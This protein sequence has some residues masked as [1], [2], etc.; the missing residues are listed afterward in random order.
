MNVRNARPEDLP[1]ILR[2]IEELGETDS[3]GPAATVEHARS[4]LEH[5]ALLILVAEEGGA[6]IGFLSATVRPNLYHGA[7]AGHVD[8]LVVERSI[9]AR[10]VGTALLQEFLERM[11]ARGAAE[12]SIG[13]LP[14]NEGAARLYRR[15][16]FTEEVRLLEQHFST[17][18]PP[19]KPKD[20]R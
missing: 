12:V 13:V 16:G 5:P 15:L 11:R 18:I 2:L 8:E 19:E 6:V 9:R 4:A 3:P 10:G 17:P 20:D 14:E 7:D 1:A